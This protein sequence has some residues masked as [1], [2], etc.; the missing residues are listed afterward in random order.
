MKQK[1][2]FFMTCNYHKGCKLIKLLYGLKNETFREAKQAPKQ[3]HQKFG[4]LVLSNKFVLNQSY[5]YV[6]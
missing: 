4:E 5:K 6:C 2:G 3:W 1:Q